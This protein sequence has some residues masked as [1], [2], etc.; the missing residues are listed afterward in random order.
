LV[1]D[2][3]E[4]LI[5]LKEECLDE[6]EDDMQ[7]AAVQGLSTVDDPTLVLLR[8]YETAS[9]RRMKWA[10]DLMQRGRSRPADNGPGKRDFDP[11]AWRGPN[12]AAVTKFPTPRETTTPAAAGQSHLGDPGQ[13]TPTIQAR[14]DPYFGLTARLSAQIE[15]I[16]PEETKPK[17]R[18][19]V[20]PTSDKAR[21]TRAA[22][23][24]SMAELVLS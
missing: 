14:P 20:R 4:R 2:Q 24:A 6:V 16:A 8:R 19:A 5:K 12:P 22:R 18:P 3:L 15:A 1:D 11:P 13:P 9:L 17:T 23:R 21:R 10:L 7:E